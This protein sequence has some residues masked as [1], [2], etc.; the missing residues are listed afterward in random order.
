MASNLRRSHCSVQ[1]QNEAAF[2]MNNP[3]THG[4]AFQ[5]RKWASSRPMPPF[6]KETNL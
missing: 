1:F 5:A 4:K 6:S 2:A 3:F